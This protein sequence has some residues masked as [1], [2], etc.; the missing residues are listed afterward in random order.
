[1]FFPELVIGAIL[2]ICGFLVKAFP[3]LIAG[4]NTLSKN[5]KKRVDIDGLSSF[6]KKNLILLGVLVVIIGLILNYLQV[7]ETYVLM[8]TSTIIVLYV[9]YLTISSGKFYR[10]G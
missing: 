8:I 2:I 10:K 7:K 3:D 6:M 5:Y 4:Y 1:M 9:I